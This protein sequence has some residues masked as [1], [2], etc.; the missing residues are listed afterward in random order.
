MWAR[1]LQKSRDD[2]D[3]TNKYN[4]V[5]QCYS[6]MMWHATTKERLNP[7]EVG[8]KDRKRSTKK[9]M[10][11]LRLCVWRGGKIIFFFLLKYS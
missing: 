5:F 6:R 10:F 7:G 2:K 4:Q 9:V 11:E 8:D 1:Y 3:E